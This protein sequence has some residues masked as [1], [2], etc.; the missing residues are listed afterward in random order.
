[1]VVPPMVG[2][3]C[4]VSAAWSRQEG[5]SQVQGS[6]L[7]EFLRSRRERTDPATVGLP[8]AG[9]R[10]T[11][12]LR[13]EELAVLAGVGVSWLTRLEQGRAQ[14]VSA[15]VLQGLCDA[16]RL[17]P[18]ERTHMFGLAGVHLPA[19]DNDRSA[20]DSHRR[21]VD[22]L[23]PNPAYLLDHHWNLA[24]WNSSE[25]DLFPVLA[26][27]G[28]NPNLLRLFLCND[29]LRSFID[30]WPMEIERLT[31]H[32]RAHLTA[33]PSEELSETVAQLRLDHSEFKAAWDRG[34]VAP[35]IPHRRIIN[36]PNGQLCFEQHR[37]LLPDYPGWQLVIFVPVAL[38]G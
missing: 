37:L 1:M 33:Y 21:L 12:G 6:E 36:H 25:Q 15:D 23:N 30:D 14:R 10:R 29:Q 19:A 22:G 31:S 18:I 38:G 24:A 9:S 8:R 17:S 7:G 11:P 3:A 5:T 4:A 2:S 26:T 28:P 27:A 34:D 16:L 20:S 35:V 13:R 32:L